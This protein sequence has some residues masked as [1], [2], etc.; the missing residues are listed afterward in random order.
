MLTVALKPD[1][2]SVRRFGRLRRDYNLGSGLKWHYR[3]GRSERGTTRPA[4]E[5][6]GRENLRR[7]C[8]QMNT[9]PEPNKIQVPGSGTVPT[10]PPRP[11]TPG[12]LVF[13]LPTLSTSSSSLP[14]FFVPSPQTAGK[15]G[16]EIGTKLPPGNGLYKL[17][18]PAGSSPGPPGR[19][20]NDDSKTTGG[21]CI[22]VPAP[23]PTG[24][25]NASAVGSAG[26][27]SCCGFSSTRLAQ[28]VRAV[29][30]PSVISFSPFL[31]FTLRLV[32]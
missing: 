15:G 23:L 3:V 28:R 5:N 26:E 10:P 7:A 31:S 22:A 24:C 13:F 2:S 21:A 30:L 8:Q 9:K 27:A 20:S 19:L 17:K 18:G 16:G 25:S 32:Q 4:F 6:Q 29:I 12:P 1:S 11:Q 14:F